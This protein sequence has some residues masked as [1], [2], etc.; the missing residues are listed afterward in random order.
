[1]SVEKR[2]EAKVQPHAKAR[3][4]ACIGGST[5]TFRF[6]EKKMKALVVRQPWT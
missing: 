5:A 4:Y 3:Q 6:D 1:M 2:N